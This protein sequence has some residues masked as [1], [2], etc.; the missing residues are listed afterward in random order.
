MN[1]E[2]FG[3]NGSA[4]EYVIPREGGYRKARRILL[5]SA[6]AIWVILFFTVGVLTR[7]LLPCLALIPV[8]VWIL[9]FFTWRFSQKELKLGFLAGQLTVT[10]QFDEENQKVIAGVALKDLKAVRPYTSEDETL[11]SQSKQTLIATRSGA[12]EGAYLAL[13]E[14]H[15]LVFEANEKALKIMKYYGG[16][17]I[18]T[19]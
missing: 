18:F 19:K 6:Y 3:S 7:I 17:D 14:G 4:F 12:P 5:L 11:L 10:R 1:S 9:S 15:A 2:G 13:W 8:S 16:S